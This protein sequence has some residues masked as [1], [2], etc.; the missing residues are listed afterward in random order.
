MDPPSNFGRRL[1]AARLALDMSQAELGATL[2]LEDANSAAPRISR[3]ELGQR[4]PDPE[5]VEVLAKALGVPAAYF[6]A[7]SDL[8]AALLV[9]IA[10]DRRG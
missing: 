2:G 5:T 3:Y 8:M 10:V 9:D 1:R 4:D 6:H 7:A